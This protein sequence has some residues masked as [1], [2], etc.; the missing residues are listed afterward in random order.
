MEPYD[1]EFLCELYGYD[2]RRVIDT[3]QLW[4]NDDN[5]YLFARVMGFLDL[6]TEKNGLMILMDRLNGLSA[7]TIELCI[8]Y[9]SSKQ[10]LEREKEEVMGIEAI[11]KMM[12]NAAYADAWIGFTDKQ[13]HQVSS[14]KKKIVF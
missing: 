6:L 5:R 13:R 1:V 4:L 8:N 12:E 3:L 11:H 2:I 7:K 9:F 10:E 14:N